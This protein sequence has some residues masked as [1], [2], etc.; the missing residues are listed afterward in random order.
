MIMIS[1]VTIK[2]DSPD[3]PIAQ[4][5]VTIFF[6]TEKGQNK[7]IRFYLPIHRVTVCED[8]CNYFDELAKDFR[9][10]IN[11]PDILEKEIHIFP[12]PGEK[13]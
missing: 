9:A 3:N 1:N 4:S 10:S 6:T 7:G 12:L 13:L 8:I 2:N 5:A 11:D